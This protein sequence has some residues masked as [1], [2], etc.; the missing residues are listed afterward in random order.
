MTFQDLL[1]AVALLLIIEG[2]IP[3]LNP[4]GLRKA[5]LTV[6]QLSDGVLRFGGLTCMVLG[7]LLLYA[8]R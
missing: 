1:T 8:V 4:P 7:C 6:S 2:V 3:F 5:L